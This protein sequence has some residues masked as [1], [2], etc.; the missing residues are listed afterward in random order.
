MTG[1]RRRREKKK[2]WSWMMRRTGWR[3]HR[4]AGLIFDQSWKKIAQYENWGMYLGCLCFFIW[5]FV[6]KVWP[7][8]A[9]RAWWAVLVFEL[10]VPTGY[11][12]EI[13]FLERELCLVYLDFIVGLYTRR[14][15]FV[16][17]NLHFACLHLVFIWLSSYWLWSLW[18]IPSYPI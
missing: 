11:W 15:H 17:L 7:S 13:K 12:L 5:L 18:M 2:Y 8:G 4:P 14:K 6:S 16:G 1:E 9:F 10:L 3:L